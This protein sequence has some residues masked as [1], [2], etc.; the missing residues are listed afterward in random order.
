MTAVLSNTSE[1]VGGG[2]T[3][4]RRTLSA[5]FSRVRSLS[6][7]C[8]SESSGASAGA[9]HAPSGAA[10]CCAPCHG[11]WVQIP[12]CGEAGKGARAQQAP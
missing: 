11:G 8:S 4:R 5:A 12:R 10:A 9:R 3:G 7:R 1:Q 6:C 2:R